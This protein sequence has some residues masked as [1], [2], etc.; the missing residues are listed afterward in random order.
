MLYGGKA[1]FTVHFITRDQVVGFERF[2]SEYGVDGFTSYLNAIGASW[3]AEGP[4]IGGIRRG[5]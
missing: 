3:E 1:M 5:R 4:F 2:A